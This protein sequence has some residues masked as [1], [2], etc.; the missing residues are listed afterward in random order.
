MWKRQVWAFHVAIGCA[1]MTVVAAVLVR[2]SWALGLG[3]LTVAAAAAARVWAR[4]DPT[5]MPY[6]MRWILSVPR[7]YQ[8][9][10]RLKDMLAL[11]GGERV[12]EIGPG[13]GEHALPTAAFLGSE[14][15][16]EVLDIQP[17]MLDHLM[18]RA[19][20]AGIGN[21]VATRG[22][23]R[24]LPYPDGTFDGAYLISVLGEIPDPDAALRELRRVLKPG[25][26]L[27][28]GEVFVDPDFIG[29]AELERR[30]HTARFSF[31]GKIGLPLAY[32]ARFEASEAT[33]PRGTGGS[34]DV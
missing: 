18:R 32:L 20:A 30:A 31:G 11:R 27:V 25:G 29:L 2:L 13:T 14:G 22:D 10:R 3:L 26:R 8:S 9:P 17:E 7:P 4:H 24:H 34:A 15:V 12:L 6:A 33:G 16:L 28:V 1:V 23:A 21:I 19:A 5:P